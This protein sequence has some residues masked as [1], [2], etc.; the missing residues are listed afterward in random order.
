MIETKSDTDGP[1]CCF[2]PALVEGIEVPCGNRAEFTLCAS[3]NAVLEQFT[4]SCSYHI[5]DLMTDA[6][7]H[8]VYRL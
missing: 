8:R 5:A 3:D 6:V 4:E 7:E 2:I 1:T